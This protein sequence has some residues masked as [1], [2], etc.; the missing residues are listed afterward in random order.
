MLFGGCDVVGLGFSPRIRDL[1]DQRLWRLDDTALPDLVEPLMV[2]RVNV[3][4]IAAHWDDL[5]HLG[6]SIHEGAVLPSLLLTKLQA[7]PRQNALARTLQEHGRL[8]K[9]L[10]ILRYPQRPEMR[11]RVGGQLNKGENLNGLRETVNFAHGG[12]IRH[13]RQLAGQVAQALCLTLV[14]NCI[15]AFN[16]GLLPSAV[17]ALRAAGFEAGDA[18]VAH[19]GPT[20]TEHISVHGR[21]YYYYYYYYYDL[22]RPPKGLRPAPARRLEPQPRPSTANR[23][24]A[25]AQRD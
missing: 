21:Y 5:L 7:F 12:A 25:S 23:R 3:E 17:E 22:D 2:N 18:D 14:V 16:A 11:R 8:V 6:A 24:P 1:A 20:V 13:R 10:F 19:V 15:A 4:L 9:T